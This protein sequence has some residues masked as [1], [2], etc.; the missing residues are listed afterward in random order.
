MQ[1]HRK[2][3]SKIQCTGTQKPLLFIFSCPQGAM[4]Q[5]TPRDWILHSVSEREKEACGTER[6]RG[7]LIPFNVVKFLSRV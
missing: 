7:V 4:F 3:D 6:G 5:S 2:F 1:G